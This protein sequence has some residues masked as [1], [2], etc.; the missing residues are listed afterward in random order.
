MQNNNLVIEEKIIKILE[1]L[2]YWETCP[3]SYKET[4]TEFLEKRN[5]P[6][7]PLAFLTR[8]N[9]LFMRSETCTSSDGTPRYTPNPNAKGTYSLSSC[10]RERSYT[11]IYD[12]K[13]L[14]HFD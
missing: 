11:A 1:D 3:D 14:K 8:A 10:L 13:L 6:V 7:Y 12:E 2:I 4:I 5:K 9:K